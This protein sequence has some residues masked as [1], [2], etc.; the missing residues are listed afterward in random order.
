MAPGHRLPER[1]DRARESAPAHRF[2]D[3]GRGQRC[4]IGRNGFVQAPMMPLTVVSIPPKFVDL[5][6][7]SHVDDKLLPTPGTRE[8]ITEW[9]PVRFLCPGLLGSQV[10]VMPRT[11][12]PEFVHV[13]VVG[14]LVEDMLRAMLLECVASRHVV[15]DVARL[16]RVSGCVAGQVVV[17]PRIAKRI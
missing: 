10:V 17:M 15:R 8:F 13:V 3:N 4:H 12:P 7:V 16:W 9:H 2:S 6:V 1:A 14:C 11:V 5:V